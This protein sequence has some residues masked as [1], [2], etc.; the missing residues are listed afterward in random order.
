[1]QS[2]KKRFFKLAFKICNGSV[3]VLLAR[4]AGVG[5]KTGSSNYVQHSR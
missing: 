4:H 2:E 1:M 3:Y 5:G